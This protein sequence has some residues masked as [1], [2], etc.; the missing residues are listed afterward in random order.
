M[1][2]PLHIS[3]DITKKCNL[4]CMHCYND[5]GFSND[6]DL[7]DTEVLQLAEQIIKVEPYSFCFCG[8]EPMLRRELMYE[9]INMFKQHGIH[10]SCVSNGYFISL[11]VAN[12]LKKA[13]LNTIQISLDGDQKAHDKLR[14][15]VGAYKKAISAIEN[16]KK[17][18]I[19]VGIAFS[20]TSWNI[21]QFQHVYE[22]AQEFKCFEVRVQELMPLGRGY[23]NKEI[24]PSDLQY[25]K[26]RRILYEKELLYY[27]GKS[28]VKIFWGD[29]VE[30]LIFTNYSKKNSYMAIRNNGDVT[31]STYLPVVFGNVRDKS[32]QELWNNGLDKI[33]ENEL[34]MNIIKQMVSVGNMNPQNFNMSNVFLENDIRIDI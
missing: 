21:E 22:I 26:L 16:L 7:S 1:K 27:N 6:D 9:I 18:Q 24:I 30:H 11:D 31:G 34:V 15:V 20:P 5:S 32:L 13:G 3:L 4:R 25:R 33:W 29:P 10:S 28:Q 19:N 12:E 2:G 17:V 23:I 8:G 14:N